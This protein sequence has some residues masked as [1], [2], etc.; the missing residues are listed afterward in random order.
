MTEITILTPVRNGEATISDCLA[1]VRGQTID[2]QHIILYGCS[3]DRTLEIIKE[4]GAG[5]VEILPGNDS[6]IYQALNRGIA[7][8]RG[9]VIG[10]LSADDFY[11]QKTVLEMVSKIFKNPAT[12]SCYGDLVYVRRNDPGRIVRYWKSGPFRKD[13]FYNGWM[14]PHPTFFVRKRIYERYGFYNPELGTA[15]DYELMLR[16]LFK[17]EI[18]TVYIPRILVCMRTGGMSSSNLAKRI[19]A[20]IM[21]RKSWKINGLKPRPWTLWMKPLRKL[22]QYVIR[23]PGYRHKP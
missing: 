22:P 4:P 13:I 3:S 2:V 16:F 20:N 10:I 19:R 11:S 18:N 21:D 14:P 17:Y 6:G 7:H 1:S 15:A 12:E 5:Q 8:A 9:D 23:P